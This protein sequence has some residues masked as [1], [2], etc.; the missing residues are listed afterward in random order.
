M[1]EADR[2]WRVASV[3]ECMI[4]M[5]ETESDVLRRTFGGDTLNTAVYLKRSFDAASRP[6]DVAYVTAL[7]TDPFSDDMMAGW[8]GLGVDTSAV[9]R[10]EG[11]LPGLYWIRV[12]E[13]G[14][15][16]FYYWRN[17]AA[18]RSVFEGEEGQALA[19]R[20]PSYDL[21]YVSG[22]TLA[23]LTDASRTVLL[24][25]LSG[26]RAAG[27][28]IAFDTNHRPRLWASR[29]MARRCQSD[30]L[31]LTDF[32]LVTYDDERS[33]YGDA[34]AGV[35]VTRL[36]AAGVPEIAVKRGGE[37]C[38]VSTE[39]GI[40]EVPV[41]PV[42]RVVDTTAAGDSFNAGYLAARLAGADPIA[43]A[44]AGHALAGRVVGHKG[45]IIP[46]DA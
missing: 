3:G 12:D 14:E 30:M 25:A 18:V 45:A 35:T 23:V 31:A 21:V 32:A 44:K 5:Q 27:G 22:I 2:T 4:E 6:S 41:P 38:L 17:E 42:A 1:A 15:R 11:R 10:I 43:A 19:A 29:E 20:L 9:R 34:D 8:R 46:E 39:G 24:E 7:G 16:T 37:P 26:V 40:V 13:A 28:R 36:Q 33:L